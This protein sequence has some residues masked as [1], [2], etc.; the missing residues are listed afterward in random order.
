[1]R[2]SLPRLHVNKANR[3]KD[4]REESPDGRL[5]QLAVDDVHQDGNPA[6]RHED[7]PALEAEY[8]PL[9]RKIAKNGSL[10]NFP[11]EYLD[12]RYIIRKR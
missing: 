10:G 2:R 11:L 3:G 1:M 5:P 9:R 8:A 7:S 6:E 4:G 12:P